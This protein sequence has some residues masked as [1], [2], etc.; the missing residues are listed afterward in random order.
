MTG[1]GIKCKVVIPSIGFG[2]PAKSDEI[3]LPLD[4]RETKRRPSVAR[5]RKRTKT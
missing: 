1:Q 2:T 5:R 3:V 4:Q